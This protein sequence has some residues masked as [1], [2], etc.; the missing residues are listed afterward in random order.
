[1]IYKMP[2]PFPNHVRVVFELPA[3]IWAD[4]IAVIGDCNGWD[5]SVTPML[6]DRDGVWRATIDL[7]SGRR[8]EFRYWVDGQWITDYHADDFTKNIHGSDNSIIIATLPCNDLILAV[9][10][11]LT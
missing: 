6:Q 5:Q 8:C 2:S 10:Q 9:T 1:M 7:L 11:C 3:N 4:R